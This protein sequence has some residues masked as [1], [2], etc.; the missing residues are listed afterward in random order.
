MSCR[1]GVHTRRVGVRNRGVQE[2]KKGGN[3]PVKMSV[4]NRGVQKARR[5][6][7]MTARRAK[8]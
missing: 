8:R 4:R 5:D 1:S 2:T 7:Y 3:D 6:D